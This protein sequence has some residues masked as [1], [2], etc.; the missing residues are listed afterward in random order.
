MTD[1]RMGRT[2]LPAV[3]AVGPPPSPDPECATALAAIRHLLPVDVTPDS[4]HL[5]RAL[6]GAGGSLEDFTDLP[7]NSVM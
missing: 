6:N 3:A 5:L 7:L 4:L 1:A 2:G